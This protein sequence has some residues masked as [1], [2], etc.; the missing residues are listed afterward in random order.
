MALIK[1]N[2]G[3]GNT[4]IVITL[5]SLP[6]DG[7]AR[8]SAAVDNTTNLFVDALVQIQ[9]KTATDTVPQACVLNVYAYASTDGGVTYPEGTGTDS[10]VTLAVPT[11]LVMIGQINI[12]ANTT[13]Y[14]SN[15]MSVAAGFGGVLP[16]FWGIVVEHLTWPT[17]G[18][19][20]MDAT[21]SNHRVQYQGI[22]RSIV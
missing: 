2:Y 17:G 18:G 16:A 14:K 13:T 10:V 20:P 7:G 12:P 9:T 1:T 4:T 15:P 5:A 6:P 19:S 8:S 22:L 21:A 3:G 11:S